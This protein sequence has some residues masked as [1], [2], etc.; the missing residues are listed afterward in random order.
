M[1][2]QHLGGSHHIVSIA[3]HLLYGMHLLIAGL[4]LDVEIAGFVGVK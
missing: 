4:A 3:L 2:S 1:F